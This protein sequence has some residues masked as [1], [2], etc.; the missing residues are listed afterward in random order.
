[1]ENTIIKQGREPYRKL[2]IAVSVIIPVTIAVLFGVKIPGYDFSFLPPVYATLNG[3]TAIF[4]ISAFIAIKDGRQKLH[5]LLMKGC[6]IL[7][8]LFL[9]MYVLYHMTSESTAFGG[10][11]MIR[12]V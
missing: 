5:E 6:M 1:M 10:I 9:V 8:S 12:Y 4:L 7:S 3:M 11:G 2:I